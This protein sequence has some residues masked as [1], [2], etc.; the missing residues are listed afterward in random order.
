MCIELFFVIQ[1][2]THVWLCE[3]MGCNT[4]GFPVLHYL[5][6]F[7]Q[8]HVHW[9]SDAIQPSHPLHPLLLLP[10]IFQASGSFPMR[11]L[12]ASSSQSTEALTV[13]NTHFNF[14]P[15]T[16]W[17]IEGEKWKQRQ[18]LFSWAPKAL[19]MMTAGHLLIRRKA[20]TSLDSVLKSRDITLPT[21]VHI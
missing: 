18:I 6:E 7:A 21:K 17:Q 8:T 20:M 19:P 14:S 9:I 1:S 15:I 3:P 5:L 12:I 2:L 10:S 11:Q 4:P 16:S 13:T